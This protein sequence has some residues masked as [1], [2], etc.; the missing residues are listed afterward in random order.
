M[1]DAI[2]DA[3]INVIIDAIIDMTNDA[4]ISETTQPF[5]ILMGRG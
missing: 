3:I 1:F 4:I 2:I 5:T